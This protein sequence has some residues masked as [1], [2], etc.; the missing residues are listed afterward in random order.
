ML[1]RDSET[2]R[3]SYANFTSNTLLRVY[4]GE[5]QVAKEFRSNYGLRV[6]FAVD[7]CLEKYFHAFKQVL[8]ILDKC[9]CFFN[10]SPGINN[11]KQKY[12]EQ[13]QESR[14]NVN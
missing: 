10:I 7:L 5:S 9:G 6:V 1:A 11:V 14:T 4:T 13:A 3:V 2:S 12:L 8:A